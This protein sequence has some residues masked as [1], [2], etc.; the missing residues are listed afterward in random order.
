MSHRKA[1]LE[2]AD[3]IVLLKDGRLEAQ[4]TLAELLQSSEE[5]RF[6]WAQT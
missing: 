2:R 4:G 1:V 5:M 3:H 6:L